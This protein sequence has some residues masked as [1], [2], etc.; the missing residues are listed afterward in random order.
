MPYFIIKSKIDNFI[1][2]AKLLQL[3]WFML[4]IVDII[5]SIY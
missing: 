1:G 2:C 3:V 4:L 5:I